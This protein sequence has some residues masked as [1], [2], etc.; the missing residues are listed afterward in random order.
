MKTF[1]LEPN[2]YR[3]NSW[4]EM[5]YEKKGL[6]DQAI[7]LRV[8]ALTLI[9]ATPENIEAGKKAYGEFGWKGY[10]QK[11]L[12]LAEE[13]IRQRQRYVTPAYNM[14]RTCARLGRKEQALGWLEKAYNEH[15]DHMVLVKVDPIFDDLRTD[16]HFADLVRRVGLAP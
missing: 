2:H 3:L 6:Y 8:K 11:E 10:W 4:L 14:A 5:A 12:D 7:E 1:E 9:G 13:R 16:P 15:S